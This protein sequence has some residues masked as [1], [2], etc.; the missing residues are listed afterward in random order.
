M[1]CMAERPGSY[2]IS[3]NMCYM[4]GG[5]VSPESLSVHAEKIIMQRKKDMYPSII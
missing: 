4:K 2:W 3:K 5:F 1:K